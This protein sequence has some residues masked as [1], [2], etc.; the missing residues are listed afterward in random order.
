MWVHF[1]GPHTPSLRHRGIPEYGDSL[2]DAYDHEVRYLDQQ[3]HRLLREID[4]IKEPTAVFISSDHGEQFLE[5]Y[6]SH[7]SDLAEDNIR[8]PMLARV[9]GWSPRSVTAP[10]SLIDLMPTI[11]ALTNTPAPPDLDGIDMSPIVKGRRPPKRVLLADTWQYSRDGQDRLDL[12][13]AFDGERKIVLD[14]R[15]HGTVAQD[16]SY[17][18]SEPLRLEG[19]AVDRLVRSVLTYI[20]ETGGALTLAR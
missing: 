5:R 11:L 18:N 12:S 19:L 10:V 20:E 15:N 7:G 13:A 3:L 1:F 9:P 8:V 2:Q 17:P 16:Q 6:R 14:R 4:K